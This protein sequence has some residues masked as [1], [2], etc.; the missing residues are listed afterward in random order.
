MYIRFPSYFCCNF[1][2]EK[3]SQKARQ[4]VIWLPSIVQEEQGSSSASSSDILSWFLT[5]ITCVLHYHGTPLMVFSVTNYLKL[6]CSAITKWNIQF[7]TIYILLVSVR[8]EVCCSK[9]I[10]FWWPPN[11]KRQESHKQCTLVTCSYRDLV[12]TVFGS[13]SLWCLS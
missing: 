10:H 2:N 11:S 13:L 9:S 12:L 6:F 7:Y 3:P 4:W 5:A 1:V 8:I